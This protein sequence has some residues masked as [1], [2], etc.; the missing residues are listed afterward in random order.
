M[1]DMLNEMFEQMFNGAGGPG[2]D[3]DGMAAGG[4]RRKAGRGSSAFED[5][6]GPLLQIHPKSVEADLGAIKQRDIDYN[7]FSGN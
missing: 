4:R 6:F 2:M 5:L 7:P 3:F 1:G